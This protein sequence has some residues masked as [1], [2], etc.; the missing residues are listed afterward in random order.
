MMFTNLIQSLYCRSTRTRRSKA[1]RRWNA[2]TRSWRASS[3][4]LGME[5]LETRSLLTTLAVDVGD[6]NW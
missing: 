2:V 6:P 1:S 4:G 3:S 5:M